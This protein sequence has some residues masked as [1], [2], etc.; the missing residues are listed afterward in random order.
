M[1]NFFQFAERIHE[2]DATFSL[3]SL[4]VYSLLT[5]ILLNGT[6]DVRVNQL[7]EK[8]NTVESFTNSKFKQLCLATKE[9]FFI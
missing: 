7:F 5:N 2:Q 6:I 3:G 9:T 1:Q 4:D 8:S